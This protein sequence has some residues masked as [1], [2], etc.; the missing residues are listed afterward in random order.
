MTVKKRIA[1]VVQRYGQEVN[2]GAEMLARWIA[3]HLTSLAEMHVITTCAVDHHTWANVYPPGE[4]ELNGV[5]I[6]RF[7]VDGPRTDRY[8][9]D[10]FAGRRSIFTQ[11]NWMKEQGPYSSD[12]L[13]YVYDS[14]DEYDL[15]IF[16][17][18]LYPPVFFGLPLVSDK[19]VLVPNAHDEPYLHLPIF[20]SLF[21]L[22]QAIIY[23][24]MPEKLLVNRVMHNNH[25]PQIVA[26]VGVD[27]P[28]DVSAAR[29]RQKYGINGRFI[30]YVGRV[31]ESKNIPELFDHFIRFRDETSEDLKLVLIGKVQVFV[32]DRPDIVPLGFVSEEDKFDAISATDV[33]VNPSLFESLSIVAMEAWL[34][35]IPTLLN[36]RCEVLEYQSRQSNG[37]LYYYSYEEFASALGM[38]LANEVLRNQLG[39]QGRAFV[40]ANYSWDVILAKY[41]AVLETLTGSMVIEDHA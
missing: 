30:L 25:V 35:G 3:E 27:V 11:L 19:A 2:G 16:V 4:S 37:G 33:L 9:N 5:M 12:L 10:L 41:Q 32:P 29:F 31:E 15:Y 24:T 18:Y 38:L 14:Y 17:T 23:N 40:I 36:G 34:M 8:H 39:S 20:R 22:P 28:A 7:V 21:H 13:N 1:M 26:G 6:H